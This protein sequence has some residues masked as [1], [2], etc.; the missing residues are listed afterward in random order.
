M[1]EF[2]KE[3]QSYLSVFSSLLM[4]G[5]IYQLYTL[6]DKI[7]N[8]FGIKDITHDTVTITK[9]VTATLQTS[10]NFVY[11]EGTLTS[12]KFR[13]R[14]KFEYDTRYPTEIYQGWLILAE[15]K[16]KGKFFL[17]NRNEP[18]N[19]SIPIQGWFFGDNLSVFGTNENKEFCQVL[20]PIV[21][22]QWKDNN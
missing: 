1:K 3:A 5:L 19:L 20:Y 15:S 13:F 22:K 7:S 17:W 14:D 18:P 10:G 6:P 21:E 11:F 2:L 8:V 4:I 12:E 9:T 16:A